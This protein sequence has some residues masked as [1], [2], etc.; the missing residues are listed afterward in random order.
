MLQIGQTCIRN[1]LMPPQVVG[2]PG[3]ALVST[4]DIGAGRRF[5][6]TCA[7][8]VRPPR[9]PELE[10]QS[11]PAAWNIVVDG[12][13]NRI[14]SIF[15]ATTET[16]NLDAAIVELDPGVALDPALGALGV[17]AGAAWYL[18]MNPGSRLRGW[19]ARTAQEA[20]TTIRSRNQTVVMQPTDWHGNRFD[21]PLENQLFCD[22]CS[23]AGDSGAAFVN[24]NNLVVGIVVG[25]EGGQTIITPIKNI[26]DHFQER[27]ALSLQLV[28]Q[29]PPPQAAPAPAAPPATPAPPVAI[30]PAAA[31]PAA[32]PWPGAV[33]GGPPAV[34]T[35]TGAAIVLAWTLWGEAFTDW[36]NGRETD[37]NPLREIAYRA[38]AE[39]VVNRVRRGGWWGS[40]IET[41]C[42]YAD[43]EKGTYQFTCWDPV[44]NA[45]N[46]AQMGSAVVRAT[47]GFAA[48]EA[49][50]AQ[51]I[52]GWSGKLTGG[53]CNYYADY[54][55]P[56]SWA[57]GHEPCKILGHHLFF[58]DIP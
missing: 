39:V 53:A 5:L 17:P 25:A 33:W 46:F 16:D 24:Q 8:V 26:L 2:T 13:G 48:A 36:R 41:V 23:E 54:L 12:M 19:G 38:V 18:G 34:G 6:L 14:G 7:H 22:R 51:T 37:G 35:S 30:G 31:A 21:W 44:R 43:A 40:T 58:N 57:R 50:A 15:A 55:D 1:S 45:T 49:V 27:F 42:Q 4:R 28:S 10:P 32:Q 29:A 20:Q 47:E 56:P 11:Q 52:A 9:H 3:C